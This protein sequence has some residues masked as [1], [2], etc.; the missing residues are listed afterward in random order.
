[1]CGGVLKGRNATDWVFIVLV[2]PGLNE[3]VLVVSWLCVRC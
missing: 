3:S 2:G 1:V